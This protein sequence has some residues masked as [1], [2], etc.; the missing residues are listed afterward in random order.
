MSNPS[1]IAFTA[2]VKEAQTRKGSRSAYQ[3]MR[4]GD[5]IDEGIKNFIESMNSVFLGTASVDG[6]P[7]IQH[8]G[9]PRGFLRVLDDQTIAFSDFSGNRQFIS[10][11]NLSENPKAYLF[12]IDYAGRQRIKIWGEATI[13]EDDPDLLQRL[14]PEDYGAR[15]EQV[16]MFK[17]KAWDINCPQHIPPKFDVEDVQNA[18]AERDEKILKLET[19]LDELRK[20]SAMNQSEQT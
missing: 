7:Y 16:L 12:L 18:L 20:L 9:G 14:T 8:R 11:G 10:T 13:I 4:M 1:D 3:H 17:V 5:R 2:A 6:Q 19:E 15:P